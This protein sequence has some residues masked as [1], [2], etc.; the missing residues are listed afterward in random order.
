LADGYANLD[1][2]H[3]LGGPDGKKDA[4]AQKDGTKWVMA[5]YFPRSQQSFSGIKTKLLDDV[6]GVA[7]AGADG[8]AF[9]TNQELTLGERKDLR[10]AAAP[11]SIELYHLERIT[12]VL[13]RPAMAAARKQF[14]DIDEADLS[15]QVGG[16][17]GSAPGAGGG[18]GGVTGVGRGGDGGMGGN[19]RLDGTPGTAPGAGGGGGGAIGP[20]SVGGGGGGGGAIVEAWLP[21]EPGQ[22]FDYSVGKGGLGG[23][24]DK[25][26]EAGGDSI[27]AG[28]VARG[29]HGGASGRPAR[30]KAT[31]D[32]VAG[33]LSAS[34]L[35]AGL[36]QT[37][38]GLVYVLHGGWDF[39]EVHSLAADV[40]WPVMVS[41]D[42]GRSV[43]GAELDAFVEVCDPTGATVTKEQLLIPSSQDR[44]VVRMNVPA[45]VRPKISATGVW[46]VRAV[47]GDVVLATYALEVQ[48]KG[49]PR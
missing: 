7:A 11:V 14:L 37:W 19:I 43:R 16:S 23:R 32:D 31:F 35:V 36:V 30:R 6:P 40:E 48:L 46:T 27:F 25:G 42:L 20:G 29:G 15:V 41:V 34:L 1:P 12:A 21:V 5:V 3:P 2:S 22:T 26:G 39:Y 47:S 24:Q 28:L 8:L 33:G 38:N 45:I 10:D 44:L 13:D 17:G 9:V 49:P 4:L 18:G